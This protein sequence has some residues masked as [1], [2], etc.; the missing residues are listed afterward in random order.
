MI[1]DGALGSILARR[2]AAPVSEIPAHRFATVVVVDRAWRPASARWLIPRDPPS[3][4]RQLAEAAQT[5]QMAHPAARGSWNQPSI[6]GARHEDR[7][8]RNAR[9]PRAHAEL[10]LRQGADRPAG[11]VRLGRGHA[12]VA[13]AGV[14]GRDR[15]PR[16]A[17]RRRGP[18]ADRAPV[19]D[20]VPPAFLAR[21]RASSAGRPSAASTSR[22][23]TSSARS[24]ACR[25][26]SSGAARCAITSALYCHLGG[27]QMED[28]LR[29][30]GRR[31]RASP[32]LRRQAV[33]D[34]FTAFKWMAVPETM[35]LEG[36][37]PIRYAEDMRARRCARPS[38]T[39][40]TSWSIAMPGRRRAM[41]LRFAK[42]LEPYGLYLFEEPCWPESRRRPRADPAVREHAD[43][44]R[45][46][47]R[48]ASTPSASCSN[49]GPAAS[50]SRTSRIAAA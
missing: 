4:G 35:P 15:G 30:A 41:G 32:S 12:R 21:Q 17:R 42:A 45:R 47:A 10:D 19:A 23:G 33:D 2:H 44:H 27:G 36:L 8:D 43:R 26:T 31:R 13:H 18:D 6:I 16:R 7:E 3:P 25:A 9:L 49:S 34:G 28:V 20:D 48:S 14:V 39:R 40:S 11:P 1:A 29:D 24:T 5:R 38:A 46:A 50:S 37:R 22:C